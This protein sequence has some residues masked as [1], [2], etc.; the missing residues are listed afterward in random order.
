MHT[1]LV[2]KIVFCERFE[3]GSLVDPQE[4]EAKGKGNEDFDVVRGEFRNNQSI[5]IT[6]PKFINALSSISQGP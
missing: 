6:T 4:A 3:H 2:F 5:C 1:C